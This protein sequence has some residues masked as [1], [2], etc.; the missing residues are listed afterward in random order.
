MKFAIVLVA[1]FGVALARPQKQDAQAT[2]VS[3]NADITPDHSSYNFS[4]QSDNGISAS[5]SGT[6]RQSKSAETNEDAFSYATHG[7]FA[8]TGPDGVQYTVKYT[9]DENGFRPEGAHLPTL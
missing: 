9:A 2:I 8:Y 1:L 4:H 5:Q 3:Q 6:L 7:Q